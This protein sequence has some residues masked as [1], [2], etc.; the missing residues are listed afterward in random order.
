M[1]ATGVDERP[2]GK[3]QPPPQA[4]CIE[5]R[6]Y[7]HDLTRR[8]WSAAARVGRRLERDSLGAG[9][10]PGT[11]LCQTQ[12]LGEQPSR[13]GSSGRGGAASLILTPASDGR[14]VR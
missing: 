10:E 4:H 1:A 11:S 13:G 6:Q 8:R 5:Y 12:R 9:D 2:N 7:G 3:A 14:A